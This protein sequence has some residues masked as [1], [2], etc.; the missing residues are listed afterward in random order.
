MN[1]YTN[2]CCSRLASCQAG[3]TATGIAISCHMECRAPGEL[4]LDL[5]VPNSVSDE[6]CGGGAM[7]SCNEPDVPT[8][9]AVLRTSCPG[10]TV[11]R[12]RPEGAAWGSWLER[13][14]QKGGSGS[15]YACASAV[16]KS[17]VPQ[18]IA[19]RYHVTLGVPHTAIA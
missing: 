19:R 3:A 10:P 4:W 1:V 18:C 7:G 5:T 14:T 15:A 11:M 9:D 17:A 16:L 13:R 12:N 8:R 2:C 6:N